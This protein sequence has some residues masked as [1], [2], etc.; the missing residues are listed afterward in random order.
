VC[1]VTVSILE[2]KL[3]KALFVPESQRGVDASHPVY[4]QQMFSDFVMILWDTDLSLSV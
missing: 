3:I 1:P 4:R 2:Y